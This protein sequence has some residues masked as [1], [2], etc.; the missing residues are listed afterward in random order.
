MFPLSDII[1]SLWRINKIGL[2]T[3]EFKPVKT[4]LHS[5]S[6]ELDFSGVL[7]KPKGEWCRGG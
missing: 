3:S 4:V 2:G 5:T 6:F 1:I 7:V